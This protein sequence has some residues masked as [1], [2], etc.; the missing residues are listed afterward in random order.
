LVFS[1]IFVCTIN[2]TQS[3]IQTVHHGQGAY[4][5]AAEWSGIWAFAGYWFVKNWELTEVAKVL[6][7][8][9]APLRHRTVADLADKL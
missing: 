8:R 6:K 3:E 9:N 2:F 7:A 1:T 5:L 4:I